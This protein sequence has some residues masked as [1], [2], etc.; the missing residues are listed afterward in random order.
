MPAPR[1]ATR[2]PAARTDHV[3]RPVQAEGFADARALAVKVVS[4]FT[5]SRQLLT[6]Q[7]HYDWGLRA[8]KAVLNTGGKL[9]GETTTE[10]GR[11]RYRA[12]YLAQIEVVSAHSWTGDHLCSRSQSLT[13]LYL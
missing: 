8:L 10:L 11:P 7:R 5:L 3:R 13:D 4:L 2:G 12:P 9:C 6:P 1:R